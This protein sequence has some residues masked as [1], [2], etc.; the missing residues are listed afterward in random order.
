MSTTARKSLP[1]TKFLFPA[2]M[3]TEQEEI[4]GEAEIAA[5]NQA[6]IEFS[7][8]TYSFLFPQAGTT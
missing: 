2:H 7:S 5:F 8:Y 1:V 4:T 3:V 6:Y